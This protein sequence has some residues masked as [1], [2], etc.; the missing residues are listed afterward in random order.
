MTPSAYRTC[1]TLQAAGGQGTQQLR[2]RPRQLE[3]G[4]PIR[5]LQ[6]D[7]LPVMDRGD[8]RPRR[9]REQREGLGHIVR[10]RTPQPGEAEP[11]LARLGEPPLDFGD[12]VPRE[13][14]EVRCRN[15]TASLRK[16]ATLRAEV[17]DRRRLWA[18]RAGSPS[19]V[20]RTRSRLPPPD[21]RR[22]VG[23][24]D[25]VPRLQVRRG[26]GE[27][28]GDA[29]LAERLEIGVIRY[30]VA[31]VIAQSAASPIG[32]CP[33]ERKLPCRAGP[34]KCRHSVSPSGLA[35]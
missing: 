27:P 33:K 26:L 14:E 23:R 15:E 24:P 1:S 20:A 35:P 30:V 5:P 17:D 6:H 12:F 22:G 3:P 21:H 10:R 28:D 16:A 29:R 18:G 9:R 19:V 34:A 4:Q 25:V 7:H 8:V 32:L 2:F 31:E 11:V 13:L